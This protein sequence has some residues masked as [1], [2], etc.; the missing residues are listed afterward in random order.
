MS[1]LNH[2]LYQMLSALKKAS[3]NKHNATIET[4]DNE[5]MV[6]VRV[7]FEG[8]FE[9]WVFEEFSESETAEAHIQSFGRIENDEKIESERWY[10]PEDDEQSALDFD[11][12]ARAFLGRL[13]TSRNSTTESNFIDN[14][15]ASI[16]NKY[17]SLLPVKG[18][19]Y[20][21]KF[22]LDQVVLK[23]WLE[24]MFYF[25]EEE[26]CFKLYT[27]SDMETKD[28]RQAQEELERLN[29]LLKFITDTKVLEFLYGSWQKQ[30]LTM[31]NPLEPF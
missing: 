22:L 4:I 13:F 1:D 21:A 17:T 14:Y 20:I 29:I 12:Q 3:E 31:L 10:R 9:D 16:I 27:N 25:D 28:W 8:K 15:Q 23:N 7:C 2:K 11:T 19:M 5:G 18:Q 26:M 6:I 24:A 30:K